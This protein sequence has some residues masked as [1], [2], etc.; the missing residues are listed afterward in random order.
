MRAKVKQQK[1]MRM[2]KEKRREHLL[3]CLK[4]IK[5]TNEKLRDLSLKYNKLGIL[6]GNIGNTN[7]VTLQY[8]IQLRELQL[9]ETK[10]LLF[11]RDVDDEKLLFINSNDEAMIN[12]LKI[13]IR[14]L[15]NKLK[16]LQEEER[17]LA[18]DVELLHQD[19]NGVVS[20]VPGHMMK[21]LQLELEEMEREIK[22]SLQDRMEDLFNFLVISTEEKIRNLLQLKGIIYSMYYHAD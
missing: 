21:P 20:E 13:H 22:A 1:E 17:I 12:C 4:F 15:K 16:I 3:Y 2:E 9:N 19:L 6:R 8:E 18:R 5:I 10:R 7:D 11:E 14:G